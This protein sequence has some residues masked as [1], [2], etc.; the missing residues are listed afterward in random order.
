[1]SDERP[2]AAGVAGVQIRRF[3][4]GDLPALQEIRRA[5]FAPVFLSFREMVGDEIAA[6]AFASADEEQ[7]GLLDQICAAGSGH[8]ILVITLG[9][10]PVGFV[11]FTIDREKRIG[12]IGL[13]AVDPAH[14]GKG[15]GSWMYER[16]LAR[17]KELG[18]AVATVGTGADPSHEAARRAYEKAGFGPA[19]PSLHYYR[20]L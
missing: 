13:N 10:E 17:M 2:P 4:S 14:A 20:Q 7:A 12:E 8:E 5:A 16:V 3:E 1:M 11:S 15:I 6:I 18:M 19:I 9:S